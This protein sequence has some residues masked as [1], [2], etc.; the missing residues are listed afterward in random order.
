MPGPRPLLGAGGVLASPP[1]GRVAPTDPGRDPVSGL[2]SPTEGGA[3]ALPTQV[4]PP[5]VALSD[6]APSAVL[7]VDVVA[8]PVLAGPDGL[9]LGPGAAE[10]LDELDDDLFAL[11]ESRGHRQGRRGRRAGRP[12][13]RRAQQPRPAA[14]AARR[15]RLGYD[16]RPPSCRGG[17][18]PTRRERLSVATS[19]GA[20]CDDAGLRALVEG[21]V[22]GS[23]EFH[24]RSEGPQTAPVARVVLA[25]LVD[26][27][28]RRDA[29]A[30][31]SRSPGRAGTPARWR[32]CPPT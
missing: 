14:G 31:R 6:V 2:T 25:G 23:F 1:G 16:R 5:Q 22:L 13:H 11:L 28:A 27:D 3:V 21:L 26:A 17:A 19:L 7:G 30:R 8:V 12:R 20:L 9:T 24:W 15:R 4:S 18:R 10:L 32:W 29:L